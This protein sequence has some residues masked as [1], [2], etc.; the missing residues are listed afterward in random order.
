MLDQINGLNWTKQSVTTQ[1]IKDVLYSI[2]RPNLVGL[3]VA[4]LLLIK[5]IK[6]KFGHFLCLTISYI[7]KSDLQ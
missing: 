4:V 6:R 3:T 5:G 2:L 7:L 1:G